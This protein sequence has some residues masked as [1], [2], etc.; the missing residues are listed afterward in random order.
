MNVVDAIG[1]VKTNAQ[2]KPMS[3]VK[4]ITAKVIS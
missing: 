4:I 3:V 2:D 1:R